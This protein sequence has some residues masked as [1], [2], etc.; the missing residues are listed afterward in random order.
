[1]D[2]TINFTRCQR[3][4]FKRREYRRA[5]GQEKKAMNETGQILG[6]GDNWPYNCSERVKY[7][8]TNN[9]DVPWINICAAARQ[10]MV[11]SKETLTVSLPN[12]LEVLDCLVQDSATLFVS[13]PG[14]VSL[15][16]R[17]Y[18]TIAKRM[19]IGF[20]RTSEGITLS[21]C[22]YFND[23]L[24]GFNEEI[25]NGYIVHFRDWYEGKIKYEKKH[26][27]DGGREEYD[28]FLRRKKV[29]LPNARYDDFSLERLPRELCK[30]IS[31]Y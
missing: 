28:Y 29:W 16:I 8:V 7:Y 3:R 30:R 10:F 2:N 20:R 27:A 15:C 31:P 23:K 13:L 19:S 9:M 24:H 17:H 6:W 12:H 11:S 14:D 1:M 4:N 5:R 21:I 25:T 26:L 18:F 22:N